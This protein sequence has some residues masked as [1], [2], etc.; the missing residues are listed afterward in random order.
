[1]PIDFSLSMHVLAVTVLY[2]GDWRLMNIVSS[3]YP[4]YFFFRVLQTFKLYFSRLLFILYWDAIKW[5]VNLTKQYNLS[6]YTCKR[7]KFLN[8]Q[9]SRAAVLLKKLYRWQHFKES[10]FLFVNYSL[11][12]GTNFLSASAIIYSIWYDIWCL[13]DYVYSFIPWLCMCEGLYLDLHAWSLWRQCLWVVWLLFI[14]HGYHALRNK[15]Q[16]SGLEAEGL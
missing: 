14:V 7:G 1:M 5:C 15:S 8:R 10:F 4:A 2:S 9:T 12:I 13:D 6:F 11:N 16:P 3:L